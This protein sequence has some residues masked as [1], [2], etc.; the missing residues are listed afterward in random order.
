M[1]YSWASFI[2]GLDP[3]N[4]KGR[5]VK[6]QDW[7]MYSVDE[8]QDMVWDANVTELA[9]PE[10]DTFRKTGIEFILSHQLDYHR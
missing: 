2:H 9:Y 3:N 7:P 10:S 5:P 4:Y 6:T 1:S 8:P